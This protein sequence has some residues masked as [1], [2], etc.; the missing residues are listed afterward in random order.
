MKCPYCRSDAIKVVD[1]RNVENANVIRRRR[2]C[3]DCSKRFTTYERL[4]SIDLNVIKSSNR[5]EKF[6]REKLKTGIVKA[7]KKRPI[8]NAQIDELIDDIESKLLSRKTTEIQTKEIGKMV[9][10]RLKKI[11]DLGYILFSAVYNEFDTL[12]DLEKEITNLKTKT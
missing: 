8:T 11:D 3:I 5:I 10:T 7:V 6:D 9:L 2:E 1:K 4:E 12:S